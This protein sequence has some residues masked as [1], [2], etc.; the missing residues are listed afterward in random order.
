MSI[1][2]FIVSIVVNPVR[3]D[4]LT[5]GDWGGG[6]YQPGVTQRALV[7]RLVMCSFATGD[8]LSYPGS[9]VLSRGDIFGWKHTGWNGDTSIVEGWAGVGQS[10][11]TNKPGSY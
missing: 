10:S 6:Y 7:S 11:C 1:V 3:K 8:A 9:I 4:W 2:H 5:T